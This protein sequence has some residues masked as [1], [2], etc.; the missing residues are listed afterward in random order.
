MNTG[1][2]VI[3]KRLPERLD[4]RQVSNFLRDMEAQL[5]IYKPEVVLDCAAVR[6]I[7]SAGIEA[8]LRCM[9]KA[10]KQDGDIKLA[11][12]SPEAAV[13]LRLT[14]ADRVFEIFDTVAEAVTSFMGF[15]SEDALPFAATAPSFELPEG[16]D[17]D[18]AS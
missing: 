9:E 14:R 12:V 5:A 7:D 6:Q 11:A 1:K 3:V 8:L 16:A 18:L 10:M 13:I 2:Q 4:L 17:L 15:A